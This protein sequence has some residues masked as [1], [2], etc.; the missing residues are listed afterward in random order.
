MRRLSRVS[1]GLHSCIDGR[2]TERVAPSRIANRYSGTAR[3][4]RIRFEVV[5]KSLRAVRSIVIDLQ[6]ESAG[7]MGC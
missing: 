4:G 3:K 2:T 7:F 6:S 1:A 5:V